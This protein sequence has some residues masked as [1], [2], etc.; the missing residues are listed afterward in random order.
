[1]LLQSTVLTTSA[2]PVAAIVAA[3][4]SAMKAA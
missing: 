1:M 4:A 3:T 2:Y